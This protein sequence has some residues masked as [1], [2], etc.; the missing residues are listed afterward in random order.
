M[1]DNLKVEIALGPVDVNPMGPS[2]L[3]LVLVD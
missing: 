3:K 1:D 2:L